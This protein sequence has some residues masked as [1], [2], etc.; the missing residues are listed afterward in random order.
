MSFVIKRELARVPKSTTKSTFYMFQEVEVYGKKMIDVREH[1]ERKD[2]SV[3]YTKVGITIP[4]EVF[5]DLVD[6]FRETSGIMRER[7]SQAVS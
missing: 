3:Q 4:M 5:A 6:G 7:V 2:G 1:F